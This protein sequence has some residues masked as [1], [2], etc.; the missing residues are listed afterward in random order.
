M[1]KRD[2]LEA[3][4]PHYT[5]DQVLELEH[6]IDVATE[7]HKNQLRKSGEPYITHPLAVAR[8]LI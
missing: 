7:S 8:N 4:K 3:A 2:V 5:P 6:A 1:Q